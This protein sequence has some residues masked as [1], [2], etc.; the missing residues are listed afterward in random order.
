MKDVL[1]LLP[2]FAMLTW[3]A[4]EDFH[5]R[6][7]RNWLTLT[8]VISGMVACFMSGSAASPVEAGAGLLVGFFML[9]PLF[10]I[11]AVGGGDV[12]LMA[13]IGAWVGFPLIFKLFVVEAIVGLLIVLVQ[14]TLQGKLFAL[15]RNS[16]TVA[17]SLVHIEQLGAATTMELG[18]SCK[19]VARPLPYSVPVLVAAILIVLFPM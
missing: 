17:I 18:K 19:T 15:F 5:A 1:P 12:K 3:A 10:L 6:K 11:G 8:L 9:F 14:C 13:G 16:A 7:I 4:I 2:M